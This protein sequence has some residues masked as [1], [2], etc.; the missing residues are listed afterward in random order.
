MKKIIEV[1]DFIKQNPHLSIAKDQGLNSWIE[2]FNKSEDYEIFKVT[3]QRDKIHVFMIQE[4]EN[5]SPF[6]KVMQ[7]TTENNNSIIKETV[8][9]LQYRCLLEA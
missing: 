3:K 6:D 4:T 9:R 5:K 1:Q 7:I 2:W 8:I